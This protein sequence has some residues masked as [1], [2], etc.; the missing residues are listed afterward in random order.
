MAEFRPFDY[1]QAVQQ[2]QGNALRQAQLGEITRE[3]QGRNMLSELAKRGIQGPQAIQALNQGGRPDLA[4][5]EQNKMLLAEQNRM[6]MLVEGSRFIRDQASLDRYILNSER[7]GLTKPGE[8][9]Q[10]LGGTYS[11]EMEDRI[12]KIRGEFDYSIKQITTN[13]AQGKARDDLYQGGNLKKQGPEYGRYSP[14]QLGAGAG[15]GA[16]SSYTPASINQ[17]KIDMAKDALGKI[18]DFEDYNKEDAQIAWINEFEMLQRQGIDTS[19]A[20]RWATKMIERASQTERGT[21]YGVNKKYDPTKANAPLNEDEAAELAALE[22][23]F[24][25]ANAAP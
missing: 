13:L 10:I 25:N 14:R 9:Q 6:K 4:Q 12:R 2:G 21:L 18:P 7:Q 5:A 23:E 8:I 11:P 24:G 17:F 22:K 15:A 1:G 16:G 3:V 20:S 19:T